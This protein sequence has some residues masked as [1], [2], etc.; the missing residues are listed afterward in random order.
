[1]SKGSNR[2]IAITKLKSNHKTPKTK[3]KPE[4]VHKLEP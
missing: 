1:M 2:K 4:P 3:I